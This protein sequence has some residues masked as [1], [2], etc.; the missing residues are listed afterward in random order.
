VFFLEKDRLMGYYRYFLAVL[1][2]LTHQDGAVDIYLFKQGGRAVEVFFF[3][4]GF[5]IPLSLEK[6]YTGSETA[7]LRPILSFYFNRFLR[8]YPIY[9]LAVLI[10]Y[11]DYEYVNFINNPNELITSGYSI[12]RHML[13][14]GIGSFNNFGNMV[15]QSWSLNMELQWYVLVP[16][17][18]ILRK[19][20]NY[21]NMLLVF[22]ASLLIT[23]L[24]TFPTGQGQEL[25]VD[26]AKYFLG[27]YLLYRCRVILENHDSKKY[28]QGIFFVGLVLY[29]LSYYY[30]HMTLFSLILISIPLSLW[31]VSSKTSRLDK[32][33]GDLA[34]PMYVL[35]MGT[36]PII[37]LQ[38]RKFWIGFSLEPIGW[39]YHTYI[40][41]FTI[42]GI[43]IFS[44]LA[45]IS[46]AYPIEKI[47]IQFK[48]KRLA[49]E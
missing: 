34:Y 30:E 12:F 35:H 3:I 40:A 17:L 29:V 31:Q 43:T 11:L 15:T 41:S 10:A 42:L 33:F 49:T 32:L 25:A 14:I 20:T 4:S 47:R 5:I 1:V 28:F 27:G 9:W 7:S 6:N 39:V 48:N 22:L 26:Y 46:I 24:F 38:L 36:I 18:F 44:Y 8:I 2:V 19:K 37:Y 16:F 23:G 21:E 13:L 45:L